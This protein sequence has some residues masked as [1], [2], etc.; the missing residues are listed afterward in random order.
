MEM[1]KGVLRDGLISPF[2]SD[3]QLSIIAS[4]ENAKY[5]VTLVLQQ[6]TFEETTQTFCSF[7]RAAQSYLFK[8]LS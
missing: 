1:Q 4:A 3:C 7:H 2:L 6:G 5:A 8:I